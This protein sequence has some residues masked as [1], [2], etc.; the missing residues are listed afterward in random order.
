MKKWLPYILFASTV[1][2]AAGLLATSADGRE[3][4]SM[5]Q[6]PKVENAAWHSECSSCHMLYHPALLPSRSWKKIMGS[7]DRHF[8][9]NASLEPAQRDEI[10]RFLT[11]NAADHQLNQRSRRIVQSIPPD[12]APV[13]ISSTLYFISR[14]DEIPNTLYQ[15]KSIGSASNCAACHRSAEQGEFSESTVRIPR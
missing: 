4:D 12:E 7:L 5:E 1:L 8:G 11:S 6:L 3:D 2:S 15:R 9:E 10:T 13:R 14:H